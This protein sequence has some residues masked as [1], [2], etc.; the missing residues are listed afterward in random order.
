VPTMAEL[1]GARRPLKLGLVGLWGLS[2]SHGAGA[3][4]AKTQ[5]HMGTGWTVSGRGN[6]W[7]QLANPITLY[8][9]RYFRD[10][11]FFQ[12]GTANCT[13]YFLNAC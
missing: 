9:L 12:S 8:G 4:A 5:D 3:T 7:N 2:L 1:I 6:R 11:L 13:S 10:D